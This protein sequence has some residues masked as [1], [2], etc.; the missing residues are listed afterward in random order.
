MKHIRAIGTV[1]IA[2]LAAISGARADDSDVRLVALEKE[3][4][5]LKKQ[6][7]IEALEKENAVLK[8]RLN[9]VPSAP[10][11]L[12][13]QASLRPAEF[14]H[15]TTALAYAPRANIVK[16]PTRMSPTEPIY[17]AETPQWSGIYFGGTLGGA[18]TR[19]HIASAEKYTAYF[20]TNS[21][22]Y[23]V[24][25]NTIA[26]DSSGDNTGALLDVF[27]GANLVFGSF[28]VGVQLEGTLSDANF[29]SSGTR[30]YSYF[31][32]YGLTGQTATGDF[33]P[34]VHS[35]WMLSALTRAGVLLNPATLLYASG[36]W[37]GGRFDYQNLTNNTFFE[38]DEVFWANG[39]SAGGGLERMIGSNWTLRAEY[40]Y[41]QFWSV[42][43]SNN[44][45]F[46]SSFPSAQTNSIQ[47]S[48]RNSMQ[49]GRIGIS[50]LVPPAW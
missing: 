50:Y 33:R 2:I 27:L 46:A 3:N 5:A 4:A 31:D 21:P 40:R 32:A 19:S 30:A 20:P 13:V 22:Q 39:V 47:T 16:A 26:A 48:F 25:G 12:P 17:I 8:K 18:W 34:H 42:D 45:N 11:P 7:R 35:R 1:S 38:P 29:N 15:V 23:K 43:V 24:S 10:K 28:L 37:T 6:L 36:G 44:F 9:V 14:A 41:T 49:V